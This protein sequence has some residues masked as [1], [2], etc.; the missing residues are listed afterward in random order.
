MTDC[1][2]LC[3]R[4]WEIQGHV[5]PEWPDIDIAPGFWRQPGFGVKGYF[6][7]FNEFLL[8]HCSLEKR[9]PNVGEVVGFEMA[10]RLVHLATALTEGRGYLVSFKPKG[11]VVESWGEDPLH[12]RLRGVYVPRG[13]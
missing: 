3:V 10:G 12:R 7:F 1:F 4:L 2:S 13:W 11:I 5:F 9:H 8:R 6:D